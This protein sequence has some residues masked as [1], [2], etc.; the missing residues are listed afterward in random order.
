MGGKARNCRI[1]DIVSLAL[2]V[3]G[4]SQVRQGEYK[5]HLRACF[6]LHGTELYLIYC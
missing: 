6:A 4:Y 1:W 2:Q 3:A 5:A